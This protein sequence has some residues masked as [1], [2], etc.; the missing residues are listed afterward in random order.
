MLRTQ[1]CGE[2][3]SCAGARALLGRPVSP[4]GTVIPTAASRVANPRVREQSL[5]HQLFTLYSSPSD[6]RRTPA[7][8]SYLQLQT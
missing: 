4:S 8:V 2:I 3:I 6:V 5:V 1:T 7:R